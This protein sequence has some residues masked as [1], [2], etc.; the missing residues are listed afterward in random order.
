MSLDWDIEELAGYALGKTEDQVDEMIN[1]STCED[2]LY[3][4][5]GV[6]FV[7]YCSIIQDLLPLTPIVKTAITGHA[8]HAFVVHEKGHSRIIIRQEI[9]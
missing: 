4:R 6:D 8:F 9:K 7:T 3:E 2:E 1:N 5:Y